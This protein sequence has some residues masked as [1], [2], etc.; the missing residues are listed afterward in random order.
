MEGSIELAIGLLSLTKL[1]SSITN[2]NFLLTIALLEHTESRFFGSIVQK[3]F[4]VIKY[5]IHY[6]LLVKL[7]HSL[8]KRCCPVSILH[9][10]LILDF[11]Y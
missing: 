5:V 8:N 3:H 10:V 1:Q 9:P 7:I 2:L 11:N 4:L 6:S